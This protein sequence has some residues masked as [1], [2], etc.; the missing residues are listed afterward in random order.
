MKRIIN[1]IVLFILLILIANTSFSY[2]TDQ[3]SISIPSSFS[4]TS[5]GYFIN[6][7]GESVSV[8]VSPDI[9]TK[10]F[11]YNEENL[12]AYIKEIQSMDFSNYTEQIKKISGNNLS[13][14]QINRLLNSI[15]INIIEKEI[16]R[17]S[18]NNYKCFR[19]LYKTSVTST[20]YMYTEQY[21]VI[22]QNI[23][24]I[25]T[26][27]GKDKSFINSSMVK[28]IINSFT[29]TNFKEIETVWDKILIITISTLILL[30]LYNLMKKNKNFQNTIDVDTDSNSNY[31][32]PSKDYYY[33]EEVKDLISKIQSNNIKKE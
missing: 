30:P 1:I 28:E 27:T 21:V 6:N 4:K 15:D 3:Y 2:F 13:E 23:G 8:Q 5:D 22:G 32:Q 18:D 10:G 7:N 12:D 25:L 26:I 31:I 29:A 9:D 19:I 16:T 20:I 11:K 14:T 17:F 33:N 24:Y